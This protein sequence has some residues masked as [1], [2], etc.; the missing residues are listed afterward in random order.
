MIIRLTVEEYGRAIQAAYE[1]WSTATRAGRQDILCDRGWSVAFEAHLTG[2]IGEL[3]VAKAI[4][5]YAPLHVNQFR[6]MQADLGKDIEVRHRRSR[7]HQLIIREGD[8]DERK[9]VLSRG[10]PPEIELVGWISGKDGKRKEFLADYGNYGMAYFVP[11]SNL[12]PMETL[13]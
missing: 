8:S 11:D 10:T 6:G 9:Y 3:A 4:G 5:V 12:Y 13:K 2:A 7:E 1:R